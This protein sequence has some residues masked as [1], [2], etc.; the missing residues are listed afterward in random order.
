MIWRREGANDYSAIRTLAST[1]RLRSPT[2]HRSGLERRG[3]LILVTR[4]S[5]NRYHCVHYQ[6]RDEL[7]AAN[8]D[9]SRPSR[10]KTKRTT[11]RGA[12][13]MMAFWPSQLM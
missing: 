5:N 1:I 9:I 4:L 6:E 12:V 8:L 10:Y 7:F 3:F 2:R 11:E 13:T